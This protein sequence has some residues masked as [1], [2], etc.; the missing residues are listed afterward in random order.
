VDPNQIQQV[1]LIS[2]PTPPTRWPR[3]ARCG[4][5]P[6]LPDRHMLESRNRDTGT[7]MTPEVL[8]KALTP[9]SPPRPGQGTGLGLAI[10]SGSSR[11]TGERSNPERSRPGTE[12]ASAAQCR[13]VS[14]KSERGT[15]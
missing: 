13:Q 4:S 1:L 7:G 12:V 5:P 10:A 3:A 6:P 8:A 15:F 14:E 9:F 11:N 2:W